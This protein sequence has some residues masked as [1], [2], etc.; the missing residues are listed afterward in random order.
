VKLGIRMK[1]GQKE[2]NADLSTLKKLV[3]DSYNEVIFKWPRAA[4]CAEVDKYVKITCCVNYAV[5]GYHPG[6]DFL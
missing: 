3:I 2:T 5:S 1:T 6:S 4:D